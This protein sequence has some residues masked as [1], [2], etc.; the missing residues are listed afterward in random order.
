MKNVLEIINIIRSSL[1]IQETLDSICE[2]TAKFFNVQRAA[3]AFFPK[4][5]DYNEYT[6]RAEYRSS[7]NIDGYNKMDNFTEMADCW[8]KELLETGQVL[9]IANMQESNFSDNCKKEYAELGVKSAMGT[10]IKKGNDLSGFLVLSEYNNIR[11]WTEEEKS[12]LEIIASHVYIAINQAELYSKEKQIAQR[13]TLLRNIIEII[14][15]SIDINEIKPNIVNEV[16]KALNADICFIMKYS[17]QGEFFSVDK[18]SEYRSSDNEK[19]FIDYDLTND[20]VKWFI[21]AF[22]SKKEINYVNIEEFLTENKLQDTFVAEFLNSYNLKSAYNFPIFY[23]NKL[24]GYLVVKYTNDYRLLKEEDLELLRNIAVQSGVALHQAELYQQQKHSTKQETFLRKAIETINDSTCVKE[25]QNTFVNEVGKFLGADR[26]FIM[27]YC[28]EQDCLLPSK[29]HQEYLSSSDEKSLVQY[30]KHPIMLRKKRYKSDTI[31][32]DVEQFIQEQKI[33][34]TPIAEYL[35]EYNVKADIGIPIIYKDELLG[36]LVVHYTKE[37]SINENEINNVKTISNQAAIAIYN[38]NFYEK[39]RQELKKEHFLRKIAENIKNNND[40]EEMLFF[41][42]KELAGYLDVKGVKIN[43]LDLS[44]NQVK[45]FKGYSGNDE[46][47]KTD[48]NESVKDYLISRS[49][50]GPVNLLI[51]DIEKFDENFELQKYLKNKNI[52]SVIWYSTQEMNDLNFGLVIL[53]DKNHTWTDDEINIIEKVSE[54]IGKVI[55]NATLY[56]KNLFISNVMHELKNPL[57]AINTFS[58]AIINRDKEKSEITSRF[59]VKIKNNTDRLNN[60]INNMLFVSSIGACSHTFNNV[61][62][63]SVL[64]AAMEHVVELSNSKNIK[65]LSE[66]KDDFIVNTEIDL[67]TQAFINLLNNAIKYSPCDSHIKIAVEENT[68]SVCVSFQ[69][70]GCG[71]DKK[72]LENIFEPFYRIDKS[73]SRETGGTGLGLYITKCILRKL[74]GNIDCESTLNIGSTFNIYL[75]LKK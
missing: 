35:K 57:A 73:R 74:G 28:K 3:V 45:T 26:V 62:L 36:R 63:L 41:I 20:N 71:I 50:V 39:E 2:E 23:A 30:S 18:Y 38:M 75:P 67:L 44:E 5:N 43:L 16:G 11:Y 70:S 56:S 60:I 66:F 19:T 46:I 33:E 1:D 25:I 51:S 65:F 40:A 42:C 27:E 9:A 15:N 55:I 6:L 54:Y 72:H 58:E 69:D 37:H 31:F 61:N 53:D 14:R 4:Q 49:K 47:L 34:D 10:I 17:S 12:Y 29:V 21:D 32:A 48:F 7:P 64:N 24:L 8:G 59:I 22:K 13:E 52:K 68:D